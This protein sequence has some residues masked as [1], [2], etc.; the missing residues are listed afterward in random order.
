[1]ANGYVFCCQ[2]I[3]V[4]AVR[5]KLVGMF[6]FLVLN[7]HYIVSYFELNYDPLPLNTDFQM[8]VVRMAQAK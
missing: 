3:N 7:C 6:L 2:M 1:M 8:V 4:T 5:L